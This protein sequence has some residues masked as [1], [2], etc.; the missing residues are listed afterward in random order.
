MEDDLEK[1]ENEGDKDPKPKK[2]KKSYNSME[3]ASYLLSTSL[4][5]FHNFYLNA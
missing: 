2:K 5:C 1:T 4:N 3:I